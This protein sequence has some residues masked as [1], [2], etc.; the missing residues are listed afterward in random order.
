M[1][2]TYR[3]DLRR[4][5]QGDYSPRAIV[6]GFFEMSLWAIAIFRFGKWANRGR[7]KLLFLP[8]KIL[9]FFAFKICES[10]TG[11]RICTDSEIGPGLLLH[12]F[13]GIHIHGVVGANCTFVQGAQMIARAN[14]SGEGWAILGD[15]VYVGAGAKIVGNVRVGNNVQ[16]GANAVVS[17]DVPE[18][19][20]VLP[21]QSTVLK[22]F[23]RSRKRSGAAAG[24]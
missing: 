16:I 11:I 8:F 6:H 18:N 12:N 20:I 23:L 3:A 2:D 22:G 9:Y 15:S 4:F 19:S 21:P 17:S 5:F 7:P 14:G 10:V 24:K 1:L 13:G